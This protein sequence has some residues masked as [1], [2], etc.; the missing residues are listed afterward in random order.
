LAGKSIWLSLDTTTSWKRVLIRRAVS[1]SASDSTNDQ[2]PIKDSP[3]RDFVGDLIHRE[4]FGVGLPNM[5]KSP[6]V[7]P[8]PEKSTRDLEP[9][10]T[11][12]PLTIPQ[13]E[14]A[15]EALRQQIG[16][17]ALAKRFVRLSPPTPK[18]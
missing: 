8:Y 12:T 1:K 16:N 7:D 17:P 10:T 11:T 6:S 13:I 3:E 5:T 4:Q 15:L 9:L 14:K 18:S 2:A